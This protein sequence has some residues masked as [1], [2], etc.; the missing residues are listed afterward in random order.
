MT[1]PNPTFNTERHV[2]YYLRCLKTFLP[3]AYTSNDSNRMLLAYLTLSGLDVLGVLQ[4]KTT[5]EEKQGYIDWLY[6]CQVPSGGFRGFPG[7]D[8]G[9]EK[10]NKDNEAWD[11]ANVPATFFALVNLLILGDDLSRVKRRGCLEWL[12]KVQRADGSFGELV[13]P[14]G[15][16]GG[17]ACQTYDGGMA[18][19]P[20]C[21]SHSGH[22]YCAVGSLDFLRRTSNDLKPPLLS[23]GS[24]QFEAL[25]TW[26]ASRQTTQLEEPH[27]DEDDEQLEV[28]ETGSLD[29]RVRGLPNVQPIEADTI[30]CAGF[31]GRCNKYA[32]TCYSFWNGATLMMLDQYS[33][34][35]EVRN[36]RYLLEKTQHLVG[37]FGKGPGDPPDLLHSYFGMVSLAFQGEAGLSPVDPTMGSSERTVR[38]LES[39]PWWR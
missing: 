29:D 3:S 24:D 31:N 15:R 7:T 34:V 23:A 39:L 32:D 13:G 33:V 30:S 4:S 1:D 27:E 6:H 12:P 38:H 36:R 9:P 8:F 14:E 18:E 22:T 20:F 11:P 21:E 35:D 37:G 10:R 19:S 26:L 28:A 16:V 2:K 17:L 5:P 25:I